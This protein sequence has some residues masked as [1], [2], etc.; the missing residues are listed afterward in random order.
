[1][2]HLIRIKAQITRF[3]WHSCAANSFREEGINPAIKVGRSE[4]VSLVLSGIVPPD[5][6]LR[7]V[8]LGPVIILSL[9]FAM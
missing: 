4:C 3:S 8:L 2:S 1:M 7:Q 5:N 6:L 9:V